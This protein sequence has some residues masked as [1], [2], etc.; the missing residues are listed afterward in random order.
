MVLNY[1][2]IFTKSFLYY[3]VLSEYLRINDI[4]NLS[5]ISKYTLTNAKNINFRIRRSKKIYANIIINCLKRAN[6]TFNRLKYDLYDS[7]YLD[8][9]DFPNITNRYL[10]RLFCIYM[11]KEYTLYKSWY[12]GIGGYDGIGWK[13]DILRKYNRR[14]IENPLWYDYFKLIK[15]M[16]IDEIYDIGW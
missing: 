9:D 13:N 4:K 1:Q 15:Q 3:D 7:P 2:D 6:N 14:I 11:V 12:I 8:V 10:K 16:P 5:Y